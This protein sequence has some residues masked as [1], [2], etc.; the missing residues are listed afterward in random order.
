MNHGK[1][2][3]IAFISKSFL[4]SF[5]NIFISKCADPSTEDCY[6]YFADRPTQNNSPDYPHNKNLSCL[7]VTQLL[8][9]TAKINNKVYFILISF[10]FC[11]C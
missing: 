7:R 9:M 8:N 1:K 3:M 11:V 4:T 6:D 10:V 5:I 2:D